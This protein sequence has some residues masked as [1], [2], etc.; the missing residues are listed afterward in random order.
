MLA[1]VE[2]SIR[3]PCTPVPGYAAADLVGSFIQRS[4]PLPPER[5]AVGLNCT[6]G[7][8]LH[9]APAFSGGVPWTRKGPLVRLSASRFSFNMCDLAAGC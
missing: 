2:T 5:E 1:S 6:V 9:S 8:L 4:R 3:Y 7:N